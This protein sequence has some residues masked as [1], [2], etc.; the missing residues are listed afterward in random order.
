MKSSE[1]GKKTDI[2][3]KDRQEHRESDGHCT[4]HTRSVSTYLGR[5]GEGGGSQREAGSQREEGSPG[6]VSPTCRSVSPDSSTAAAAHSNGS[7]GGG[8]NGSSKP[9]PLSFPVSAMLPGTSAPTPVSFSPVHAHPAHALPLQY[10]AGS[11]LDL[12]HL[13]SAHL[14]STLGQAA[15]SSFLNS[16][17]SLL[18]PQLFQHLPFGLTREGLAAA[19]AA[20]AAASAGSHFGPLFFPRSPASRFNPYGFPTAHRNPPSTASSSGSS[21][22]SGRGSSPKLCSPTA[23]H[24]SPPSSSSSSS[25]S[26]SSS[27]A[28]AIHSC[29]RE[30]RV[31]ES[32]RTPPLPLCGPGN[33]RQDNLPLHSR[34]HGAFKST[35]A[36]N[37]D[38]KRMERMLTGLQREGRASVDGERFLKDKM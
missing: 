17:L 38:L 2:V 8:N 34:H 12:S 18:G 4:G 30:S 10:L 14:Q 31:S 1:C 29:S 3:V 15:A 9:T 23:V 27:S 5:R 37:G 26:S 6:S 19:S 20:A 16:H 24:S 22:G 36:R 35:A 33:E 7:S 21:Q 13:A 11:H 28:S 32:P 25:T